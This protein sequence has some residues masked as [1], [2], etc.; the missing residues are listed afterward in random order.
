[1]A[2][3]PPAL[4]KAGLHVFSPFM[5]DEVAGSV[6]TVVNAIKF[7]SLYRLIEMLR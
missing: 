4:P 5:T 6:R 2:L 7:I 3:A 1:M